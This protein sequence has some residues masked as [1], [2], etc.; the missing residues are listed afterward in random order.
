MLY[1]EIMDFNYQTNLLCGDCE[2]E[3]PNKVIEI[4]SD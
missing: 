3:D 2:F 4:K 1:D